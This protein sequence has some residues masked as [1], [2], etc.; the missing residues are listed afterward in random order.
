M[1]KRRTKGDDSPQKWRPPSPETIKINID[2]SFLSDFEVNTQHPFPTKGIP[3]PTMKYPQ[4]QI[5]YSTQPEELSPPN[6]TLP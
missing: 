3:N 1:P 2:A 4:P 5:Q 6:L